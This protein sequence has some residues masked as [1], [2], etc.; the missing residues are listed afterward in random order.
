MPTLFSSA[1]ELLGDLESMKDDPE[2]AQDALDINRQIATELGQL[3]QIA[4]TELAY[5]DQEIKDTQTMI[6]SQFADYRHLPYRLYAVFVHHGSVEFGH[7]YIYIYDFKKEVWRKYNDNDI[8]E[9]HDLSEIFQP[10]ERQNPPTPYFLVYVNDLM[11]DRLVNPVCRE[12]F[13]PFPDPDTT[14]AEATDT[15]E[16]PMVTTTTTTT[17]TSEKQDVNMDPPAYDQIWTE[18]GAPGTGVP[19]EKTEGSDKK[20]AINNQTDI[21]GAQW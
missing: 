1:Q 13:D 11:K 9:V 8:S 7:Y 10:Q 20:W 14:M 5:I 3:S 4:Q 2:T 19:Q 12:I 21:H 17:T 16:R 15:P 6:S 18:G